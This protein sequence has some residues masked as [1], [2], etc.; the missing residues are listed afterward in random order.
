MICQ[1]KEILEEKGIKQ[2]W[3]AD[4]VGIGNSHL[5]RIIHGVL[6]RLDLAYK[7]AEAL[8]LTVY[9]IWVPERKKAPNQ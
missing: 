1:L 7:I 3:L 5:S 6:P 8:D 9:D 4:K 2:S